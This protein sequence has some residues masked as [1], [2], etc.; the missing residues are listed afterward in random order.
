MHIH[1]NI[2]GK[3]LIYHGYINRAFTV[4]IEIKMKKMCRII[5]EIYLIQY[6]LNDRII[7]IK[8]DL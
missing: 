1:K 6:N 4:N 3:I 8:K 2:R 7:S 5:A